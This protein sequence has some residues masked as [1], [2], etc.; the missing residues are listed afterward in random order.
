MNFTYNRFWNTSW[1]H[2][3]ALSG[4]CCLLLDSDGA[5][6]VPR[7][8]ITF[9]L[10]NSPGVQNMVASRHQVLFRREMFH[11]SI[12]HLIIGKQSW[13]LISPWLWRCLWFYP[14]WSFGEV[15]VYVKICVWHKKDDAS[16]FLSACVGEFFLTWSDEVRDR[17]FTS[18]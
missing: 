7:L 10:L 3:A 14:P 9:S 4:L 17:R 8:N 15:F 2:F 5:G 16:I 12:C 6:A 18:L 13:C 1:E 11:F